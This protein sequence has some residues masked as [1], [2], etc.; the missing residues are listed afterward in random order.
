[1]SPLQRFLSGQFDQLFKISGNAFKGSTSKYTTIKP[2]LGWAEY[3]E[4]VKSDEMVATFV[5]LWQTLGTKYEFK[6]KCEVSGS[7]KTNDKIR[8][9]IETFIKSNHNLHLFLL[10]QLAVK[11]NVI[12][13]KDDNN[14]LIG[15]YA[16]FFEPYYDWANN[17]FDKI[18]MVIDGVVIKP[19]LQ[20]KEEIYWIR[21]PFNY[22]DI[23]TPPIDL[24]YAKILANTNLW[25]YIVQQGASGLTGLKILKIKEGVID[26]DVRDPKTG[27]TG[28]ESYIKNFKSWYRKTFED[29]R[30]KITVQPGIED[31]L[32]LNSS[33]KEEMVMEILQ[34]IKASYAKAFNLSAQVLGEGNTTFSNVE[35][36]IDNEWSRVGKPLQ[37]VI[38]QAYNEWILPQQGIQISDDL[39]VYVEKPQDENQAE[40]E[41]TVI[42]LIG[43]AGDVLNIKEKREIIEQIFG[44]ELEDEFVPDVLPEQNP[45]QNQNPNQKP[46]NSTEN[47][48]KPKFEAKFEVK[49]KLNNALEKALNSTFY[50][51]TERVKG[52]LEK[53]GLKPLLEKS[54]K[55]QLERTIAKIKEQDKIDL[56]KQ[57]VKIESVLPFPVLKDNLL[58]FADLAKK[59]VASR[60]KELKNK[61]KSKAKFG[62]LEDKI[63]DYLNALVKFNLQGYDSLEK[64]EKALLGGFDGKY[65]GFDE[66]TITQIN[67]VLKE[68]KDGAISEIVEALNLLV[69]TMPQARAELI[70]QMLVANAVEKSRYIEYLDKDFKFKRH[71]G[72]ND[73]RETIYST[74][75]S[76]KGVVPIDFVYNHQIGDGQSPPLHFGERS[77][78][79]YGIEES[80]IE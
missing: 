56:E 46:Q 64:S 34:E 26:F 59:E 41:K 40:K 19:N 37:E 74:E 38:C 1:M 72:V 2:K 3:D 18:N 43:T 36:L 5:N 7:K 13:T 15:Q 22:F 73:S 42:S 49:K 79:I 6:V 52:K 67:T 33:I 63:N 77:S 25:Q 57:F 10:F 27:E 4:I 31:V 28:L 76:R 21:N 11:G 29:K 54:I 14:Q 69:E 75:A 47:Q 44:F 23:G 20:N 8:K 24:A 53:K 48:N 9:N 50:E 32:T 58:N 61:S 71:L 39:K 51:R 12:L 80:D 17:R 55:L 66:E 35:T 78:M 60:V 70:S 68:F 16:D 65:K 30:D 62:E 45:Q